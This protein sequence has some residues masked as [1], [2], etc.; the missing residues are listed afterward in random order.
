MFNLTRQERK[1]IL[2][3]ISAA[4]CGILTN[5]FL[6]FCSSVKGTV[7]FSQNI[8]KLNLNKA[9]KESLKSVPGIGEKLAQRLIDYRQQQGGFSDLEELRSIKGVNESKFDK[10]SASLLIE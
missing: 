9:D 1:V 8:G 4:F 2:F 6:K 10:I 7:C 5:L 3:L